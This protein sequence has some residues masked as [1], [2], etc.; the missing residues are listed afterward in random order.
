MKDSKDSLLDL[1]NFLCFAIYSTAN[2]V[3]RAYQP[4]LAALGLTYPQYLVMVVLWER[5]NRTVK[6]IGDKLSLDSGTLTP[7]LK[8]LETAGLITR[9][10]DTVD[11]RQVL[12]ALTEEGRAMRERAEAVPAAMG[13]AFGCTLEE[14]KGLR[15]ELMA[16]RDNLIASIDEAQ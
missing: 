4:R 9:R 15:A 1:E 16:M 13:Q 5:E 14:A 8:R 6:A 7:L 3:T 11:E 10:R 2:A 12:I